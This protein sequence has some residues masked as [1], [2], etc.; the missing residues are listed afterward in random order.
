MLFYTI[1]KDR[2]VFR[3]V[4]DTKLNK[5][6]IFTKKYNKKL[7][8]TNKIS[9]FKYYEQEKKWYTQELKDLKSKLKLI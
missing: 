3:V 4:F 7:F 1:I 8:F 6:V 2:I 5:K 9:F